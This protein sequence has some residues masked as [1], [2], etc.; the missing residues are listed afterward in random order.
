MTT[1]NAE[2]YTSLL[3]HFARYFDACDR[4]DIDAVVEIMAGATI[5]VGDTALSDPVAIRE[6]YSSRQ[7]APL[8]DGRRLTKHH[9]TNMLVEPLDP[10]EPLEGGEISATVYY[11]RLQPG[12]SG[13]Y[14]AASGRLNEVVARE[15]DRWRV[16]RHSI[17]SDF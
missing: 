13:P 12:E 14:V 6:M 5:G 7:A 16:I 2:V 17:V 11:F 3:Q 4:C 1:A 8:A 15:G 9:V 10:R